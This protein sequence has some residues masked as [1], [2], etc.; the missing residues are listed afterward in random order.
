MDVWLL[1]LI[2]A[3]QFQLGRRL[4]FEQILR[5]R[6]VVHTFGFCTNKNEAFPSNRSIGRRKPARGETG[7]GRTKLPHRYAYIKDT[8]MVTG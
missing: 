8:T 6:R 1:G 4:L 7:P 2:P 5:M 3:M